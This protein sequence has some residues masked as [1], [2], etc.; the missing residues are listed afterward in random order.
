MVT[1]FLN[2]SDEA[3][4]CDVIPWAS[5]DVSA[6]R[7]DFA[8]AVEEESER[9]PERAAFLARTA[10]MA[11]R[12]A[13]IRAVSIDPAYPAVGMEDLEWGIALARHSADAMMRGVLENIAENDDQQ[14]YKLVR[15]IVT[16]GQKIARTEL[17][18]ALGGRIRK[19]ALDEIIDGLVEA[20]EIEVARVKKEGSDKP[21]TIYIARRPH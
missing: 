12:L 13:T 20:G 9:H 3:P 6:A 18:K 21:V 11:V 15:G 10:E 1:A 14:N 5:P 8:N 7:I 17:Y 19:R 16:K 2:R 4:K